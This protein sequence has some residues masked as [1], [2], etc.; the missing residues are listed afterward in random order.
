MNGYIGPLARQKSRNP[1][2]PGLSYNPNLYES[3]G[4]SNDSGGA[5]A[6]LAV[7]LQGPQTGR[8][9]YSILTNNWETLDASVNSTCLEDVIVND[10]C[11]PEMR[12]M[13]LLY[14]HYEA[15]QYLIKYAR[16]G[17]ELALTGNVDWNSGS[18]NE[19]Y[20]RSNTN[21]TAA[22]TELGNAKPPRAFI[23]IQG[24]ADGGNTTWAN[25]YETNLR[26]FILAKRNAYGYAAMPFIIVRLS[27]NQTAIDPTRLNTIQAAQT[28]V[29]AEANNYLINT[30]DLAVRVDGFHYAMPEIEILAQRIFDVMIT[31]P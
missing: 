16:D 28:T 6:D 9:I 3:S 21:H 12:L 26:A 22:L 25:A 1:A 11:G 24:E 5:S 30:N 29:A 20:T 27:D 7:E 8:H 23:W 2:G 19:V 13:K 14:D 4:Q 15:D 18:S 17:T 10:R 31:L